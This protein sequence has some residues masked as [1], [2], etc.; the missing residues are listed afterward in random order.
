M[1]A[2][3]G[4]KAATIVD[5]PRVLD[6]VVLGFAGD[7]MTRWNWPEPHLYLEAMPRFTL[8]LGGRA[9]EHGTAFMTEG[10]RGVALWLPPGAEPDFNAIGAVMRDTLKD[11]PDIARDIEAVVEQVSALHPTEPHWYLPFI[12]TDPHWNGTGLGSALLKQMLARCD[13]EKR[14]AYLEATSPRNIALYERHG[15]EIVGRIQ[16]GGSPVLTPMFRQPR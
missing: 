8:A 9:F 5:V 14:P 13:A 1:T 4:I 2:L 15:F 3:P 10:C 11:H 7:P 6:T 16:A 12:A